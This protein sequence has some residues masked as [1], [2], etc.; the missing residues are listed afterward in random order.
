[1]FAAGA[2]QAGEAGAVIR[3]GMAHLLPS[4]NNLAYIGGCGGKAG[5]IDLQPE[6]R[7]SH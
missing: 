3:S 5:D 6:F 1:M 4:C 2:A 7:E